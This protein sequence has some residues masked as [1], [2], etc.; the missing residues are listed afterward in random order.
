M[1]PSPKCRAGRGAGCLTVRGWSADKPG[2]EGGMVP[3]P[4]DNGQQR[5]Q[6]QLTFN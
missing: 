5:N 1:N 3:M 2:G 4:M 6:H